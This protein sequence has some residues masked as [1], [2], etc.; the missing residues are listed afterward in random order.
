MPKMELV[1]QVEVKMQQ[2]INMEFKL[3]K[4]FNSI[5]IG[6]QDQ[7][8]VFENEDGQRQEIRNIARILREE[9]ENQLALLGTAKSN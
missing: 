5:T 9:T 3:S 1:K 7:P 2:K 6:I 4:N 8:I